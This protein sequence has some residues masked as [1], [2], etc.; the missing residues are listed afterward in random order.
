MVPILTV[1]TTAHNWKGRKK[2]EEDKIAEKPVV[3][4]TLNDVAVSFS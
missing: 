1:L 4:C 2:L 3:G